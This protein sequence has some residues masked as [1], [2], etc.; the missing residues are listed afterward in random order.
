MAKGSLVTVGEDDGIS[1]LG[2]DIVAG[3]HTDRPHLR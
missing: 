2:S 3:E 1:R